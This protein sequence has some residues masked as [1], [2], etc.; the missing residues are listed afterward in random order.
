[1]SHTFDTTTAEN[2][3]NSDPQQTADLLDQAPQQTADLLDQAPSRHAASS[4]PARRGC[5][6]SGRSSCL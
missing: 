2:G 3:G 4:C 5:G 6:S 1:M